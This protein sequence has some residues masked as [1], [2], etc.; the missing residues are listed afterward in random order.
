MI[1]N[2]YNSCKIFVGNVPFQCNREEFVKCFQNFE[3]FVDGDIIGKS[4]SDNSRGFGFITFKTPEYANLFLENKYQVQLKSR[5]LRF[6]KYVPIERKMLNVNKKNYLFV[7]NIPSNL[8]PSDVKN[9][10]EHFGQVGTCFIN[11]NINTGES[12]GTAV[13][14]II[15]HD[16]FTKLLN[17]KYINY[18]GSDQS[19]I[20]EVMKWK[21]K[22]KIKKNINHNVNEIYRMAFNAGRNFGIME[23]M[24]YIMPENTSQI[25]HD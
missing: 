14:E 2:E 10:F 5:Y 19:K 18:D 20:F 1:E 6:T 17:M 23:S 25:Y 11:T 16:I 4:N 9:I 13:V 22:I 3:G 24:K 12:K 21:Q 8:K 15:E 7:K